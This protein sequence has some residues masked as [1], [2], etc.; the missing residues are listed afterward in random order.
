[1]KNHK[2]H[3]LFQTSLAVLALGASG[4]FVYQNTRGPTE[5]ATA[6]SGKS[7]ANLRNLAAQT[8]HGTKPQ[9]PLTAV[10]AKDALPNEAKPQLFQE[11]NNWAVHYAKATPV[12]QQ[13]MLAHGQAMVKQRHEQM[14]GLIEKSPQVALDESDALSPLAREALPEE[15][16]TQLEQP[17][18]ARGDL[19]VIAAYGGNEAPYRRATTL[20]GQAYTVYPAG[21]H[22]SYLSES[23]RSL[24]GI[25]LSVNR[26]KTTADGKSYSRVD[27]VIALRRDR[28]RIL[29]NEEV[30]VASKALKKGAE[31]VCD[32]STKS[33]T[34]NKTPAAIETGGDTK[35][36]C[37]PQHAT[38]WLTTAPGVAAAVNSNAGAG[39][40]WPLPANYATGYKQYLC[41][42]FLCQ[43]QTTSSFTN[44][45]TTVGTMLTQISRWSYQRISWGYSVAPAPLKLPRTVAQYKSGQ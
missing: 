18:N 5:V 45:D 37:S 33:V 11:F 19:D 40:F 31:P 27:R 16:K 4:L 35:W 38:S 3:R 39:G 17:V 24:L 44:L 26:T 21:D 14:A 22:E 25:K 12:E 20:D 43:D 32:V 30:A 41:V 29:S 36:L 8:S 10:A 9:A 6:P 1:M 23:N 34:A 15:L 28:V 7:S 2:T 13:Q 42:P